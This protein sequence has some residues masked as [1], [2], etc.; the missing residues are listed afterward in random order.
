M[1]RRGHHLCLT[2]TLHFLKI[3]RNKTTLSIITKCGSI[4]LFQFFIEMPLPSQESERSCFCVLEIL[5]LPLSTI[6]IFDFG[7]VPTVWY[8]LLFILLAWRLGP[9]NVQ[10]KKHD[11]S[12]DVHESN[13]NSYKDI[14]SLI[15]LVYMVSI[16]WVSKPGIVFENENENMHKFSTKIP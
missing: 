2:D 12:E 1:V 3:T 5:I 9:Y 10:R 6:F 15:F 4:L 8:F 7:I 14:L 13:Q 16:W 11:C